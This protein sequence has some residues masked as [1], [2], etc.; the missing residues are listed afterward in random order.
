MSVS[1]RDDSTQAVQ[2][3]STIIPGVV[4]GSSRFRRSWLYITSSPFFSESQDRIP[5]GLQPK[6]FLPLP[7]EDLGLPGED[8]GL[9]EENLG[10]PGEDLG[11]REDNGTST[12]L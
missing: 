3:S 11:R 4:C 5:G 1:T 9:P 12:P 2:Q 10:L 6:G 7:G 8:L